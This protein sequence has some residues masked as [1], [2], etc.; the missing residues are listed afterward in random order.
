MSRYVASIRRRNTLCW[1]VTVHGFDVDG[2]PS[3]WH[4][5]TMTRRGARRSARRQMAALQRWDTQAEDIH[6]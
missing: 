2:R 6:G 1:E 4:W 5:T 3:R